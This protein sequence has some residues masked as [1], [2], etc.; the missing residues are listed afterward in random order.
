[1]NR[2]INWVL[3]HKKIMDIVGW[4]FFIIF[5]LITLKSGIITDPVALEK[6]LNKAG[7][8]APLVFIFVQ[9]IQVVIPI[10]PGA[11]G[12]VF[13]V[14][15]FGPLWGFLLNY[16]G[17][18]LGSVIAFVLSR[19][20]GT[21][22]ARKMTG[23]KFYDK[24]EKFLENETKF[25]KLFAILIFFP[26]APDDFLCYLAGVSRMS[27]QKFTTIILLGKPLAIF[28]Y[29]IGLTKM[30]YYVTDIVNKGGFL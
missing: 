28:I 19:K 6:A 24:Y 20:Y 7:I 18:C 9:A 16:F 13:G 21:Q 29:T 12:N 30:M 8:F 27:L 11:V 5:F 25:E 26:F 2:L 10:L 14:I 1:M 3:Q 22:F 23:S 17:I 4:L 15:F